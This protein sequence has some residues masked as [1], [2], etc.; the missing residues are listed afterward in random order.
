[1]VSSVPEF[2]REH[3]HPIIVGRELMEMFLRAPAT[4]SAREIEHR[5][6]AHIQYVGVDDPLVTSNINTPADYAELAMK[7][8]RSTG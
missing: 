7:V 3:G 5:H 1:M 2:S 8:S 6:Q 4:G